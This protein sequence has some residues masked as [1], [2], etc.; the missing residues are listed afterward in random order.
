MKAR[1]WNI[2]LVLLIV[3]IV[4]GLGYLAWPALS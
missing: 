2:L 3:A 1:A 4:A